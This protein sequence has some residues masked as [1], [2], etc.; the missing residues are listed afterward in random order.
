MRWAIIV[1]RLILL[2]HAQFRKK[3]TEIGIFRRD[4]SANAMRTHFKVQLHDAEFCKVHLSWFHPY[5]LLLL[6]A[7]LLRL[8]T[9]GLSKRQRKGFLLLGRRSS[10]QVCKPLVSLSI[11]FHKGVKGLVSG[12]PVQNLVA[13]AAIVDLAQRPWLFLSGKGRHGQSLLLV[14]LGFE[15]TLTNGVP[16]HGVAVTD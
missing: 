7:R 9:I 3:V 8:S 16:R 5:S 1:R 4:F 10:S 6:E 14:H 15:R 11:G 13:N 12:L 2:C